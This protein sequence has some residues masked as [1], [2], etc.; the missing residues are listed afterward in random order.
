[1]TTPPELDEHFVVASP[2]SAPRKRKDV[3]A[4]EL[5]KDDYSIFNKWAKT[6]LNLT[7]PRVYDFDEFASYIYYMSPDALLVLQFMLR[8]MD[9]I[10]PISISIPI[11]YRVGRHDL[12]R[13]DE[14]IA[15]CHKEPA[16]K[17]VLRTF[18]LN[19]LSSRYLVKNK[20]SKIKAA[21]AKV[22]PNVD[23]DSDCTTTDVDE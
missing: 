2:P 13:L 1:M 17:D 15:H 4:D 14:I 6:E 16:Y 11:E 20:R 22:D 8:H 12:H 9:V 23:L 19:V 21:K 10:N 18:I 5:Y 3:K 7:K